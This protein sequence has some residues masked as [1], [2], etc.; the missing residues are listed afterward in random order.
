MSVINVNISLMMEMTYFVETKNIITLHVLENL[1]ILGLSVNEHMIDTCDKIMII[2]SVVSSVLIFLFA[3][4]ND[5]YLSFITGA[6]VFYVLSFAYR[7]WK[8]R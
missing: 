5:G 3:V 1:I 4:K 8:K 6:C 2:C 7:T